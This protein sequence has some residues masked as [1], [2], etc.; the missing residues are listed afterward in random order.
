M[1]ADLAVS[2]FK[3]Y[4]LTVGARICF[5]RSEQRTEWYRSDSASASGRHDLS[6]DQ[7]QDNEW[8]VLDMVLLG[9][10]PDG[11]ICSLFP[12]RPQTSATDVRQCLTSATCSAPLIRALPA[13]FNM[14][15]DCRGCLYSFSLLNCRPTSRPAAR[16][17]FKVAPLR[18][19]CT[20]H[21]K[22]CVM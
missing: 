1:D 4:L 10:G 12:N 2:K 8:P 19:L 9:V 15:S 22:P 16:R 20:A 18:L 6:I 5:S 14:L 13:A 3:G 7:L 21:R 11:H 17:G